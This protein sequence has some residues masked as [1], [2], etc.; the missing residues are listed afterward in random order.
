MHE[1]KTA[2]ILGRYQLFHNGHLSLIDEAIKLADNVI[3]LI[4]S[5]DKKR[6]IDNPFTYEERKEMILAVRPNLK[7]IPINDLG[8]GDVFLWGDYLIE[9]INKIGYNPDL[10]IFGNEAKVDKW[11]R[12]EVLKNITIKKVS[13]SIIDISATKLRNYIIED[14]KEY[15]K[16]IPNEIHDLIPKI[17]EIL[18]QI[19]IEQ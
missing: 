8:V 9:E 3:V 10:F 19:T 16:Y 7:I 14:N 11:F 12:P 17:K 5:S 4:G 15:L 6:T 1:F 2:F 18:L 13:R